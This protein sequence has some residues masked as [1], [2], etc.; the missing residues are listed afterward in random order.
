MLCQSFSD[1]E[2]I[3]I[4]DS[5]TDDSGKKCDEYARE[6]ECIRVIHQE[7]QG[8]GRARNQGIRISKGDYIIFIDDD[9]YLYRKDNLQNLAY[10][11]QK[12]SETR[13][14]RISRDIGI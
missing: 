6:Y 7:N 8:P 10:C 5:S 12:K 3:L 1:Y 13:Y 11:I 2:I 9:D 4:N 14:R